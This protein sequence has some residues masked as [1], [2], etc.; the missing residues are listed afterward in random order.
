MRA[1]QVLL[2]TAAM[3]FGSGLPCLAQEGLPPNRAPGQHRPEEK[4]PEEKQQ[5]EQLQ[6]ARNKQR[7]EQ[8]KR[9]S[10][11]L[12]QLATELKK[13]VDQAD[14]NVLSLDVIRKAEEMEKLARDVK[15][16]MRE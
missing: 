2:L 4:T 1:L 5:E 13:Y 3:L 10:D 16:K 12:L 9:D 14:E 15:N 8:L 7:Y 6:K 11:R